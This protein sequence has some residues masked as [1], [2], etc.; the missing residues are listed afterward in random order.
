MV[1]KSHD[2]VTR[3]CAIV[4]QILICATFCHHFEITLG[5]HSNQEDIHALGFSIKE[6]P[7]GMVVVMVTKSHDLVTRSCAS[8]TSNS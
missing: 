8:S 6:S 4:P 5:Y 3:S 2:L 7:V 1:T